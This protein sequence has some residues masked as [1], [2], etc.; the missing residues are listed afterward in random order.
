MAVSPLNDVWLLI[1]LLISEEK[2]GNIWN[3]AGTY[4]WKYMGRISYKVGVLFKTPRP[5]NLWQKGE[6]CEESTGISTQW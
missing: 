2:V 6:K 3:M 4:D 1:C 5:I